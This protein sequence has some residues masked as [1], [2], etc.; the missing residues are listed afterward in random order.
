MQTT[1]P[2]RIAT[3]QHNAPRDP[4]D[5]VS[6][7]RAGED[8]RQLMSQAHDAGARLIHFC[9]GALCSPNK[10]LLSRDPFKVTDADW[11]RFDWA[12]QQAELS[13]IADHARSLRLWTLVGAVHRLTEP[14][15]PHNS[16]YVIDDHGRVATRYDERM[17]SNTKV[18]YMY[19]P[20][21]KPITFD[22]DGV[23]FGC[24]LGMETQYPELF[25]EY[26][27]AGVH[28]A[29]LSTMDNGATFAMQAQAHASVNSYWVSYATCTADSQAASSGIVEATGV[30]VA[31]CAAIDDPSIAIADIGREHE[32]MARPWRRKA[33]GDLYAGAAVNEDPRLNRNSF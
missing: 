27:R 4:L 33:R 21:T 5:S 18:S 9:E 24:A 20:G 14:H 2:M 12:A 25:A 3:A 23:R 17:L 1:D 16:L 7:H 32:G 22:V 28:C 13:A 29:A 30:W 8:I 11:T 19:T 26:E 10:R 15:R 31:R 6:M